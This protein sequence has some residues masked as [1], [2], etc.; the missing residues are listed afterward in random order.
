[1]TYPNTPINPIQSDVD[2]NR[3]SITKREY[4]AAQA[5]I[6]LLANNYSIL[7]NIPTEAVEMADKLIEELNKSELN[8]KQ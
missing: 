6:G 5:M 8:E 4:F 2:F 1:M 7:G 3:T